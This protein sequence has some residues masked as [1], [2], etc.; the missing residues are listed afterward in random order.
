MRAL[1][2]Y[3]FEEGLLFHAILDWSIASSDGSTLTARVLTLTH[4][5]NG[6]GYSERRGF[7]RLLT[8]FTVWQV[9]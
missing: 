2:R 5:A 1:E 8:L 4:E 9:F 6:M 3:D 7:G